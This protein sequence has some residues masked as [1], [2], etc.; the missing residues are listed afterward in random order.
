MHLPKFDLLLNSMHAKKIVGID[1]ANFACT[2]ICS[3]PSMDVLALLPT[4]IANNNVSAT[5]GK[6]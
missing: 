4:N 5:I 3:I 1:V 6:L 2:S